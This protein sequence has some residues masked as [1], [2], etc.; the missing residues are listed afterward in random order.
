MAGHIVRRCAVRNVPARELLSE[1]AGCSSETCQ[2]P[3]NDE[4]EEFHNGAGAIDDFQSDCDDRDGGEK[5]LAEVE[6]G[7]RVEL[8]HPVCSEEMGNSH[9]P[10]SNLGS[11]CQ[12][13]KIRQIHVN[14]THYRARD[15][16]GRDRDLSVGRS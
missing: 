12:K 9:S 13:G 14:Q 11:R 15:K 2:L 3:L 7:V 5:M 6:N 8:V 10:Q 16:E 4:R 1:S